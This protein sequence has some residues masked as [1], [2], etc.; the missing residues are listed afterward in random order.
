VTIY[1]GA[2]TR[3]VAFTTDVSGQVMR[4]LDSSGS[5]NLAHDASYRLGGRTIGE[6]SSSQMLATQNGAFYADFDQSL[7]SLH[8][9]QE[10][11]GGSYTVL[12][13]ETLRSIAGKLWGD[14][15][16]WY[17]LA[18]ANGLTGSETLA[19]GSQLVVPAGVSTYRNAADTFR[20]Y[21]PNAA[22]G[23]L[24][25]GE[26]YQ[27]VQATP[28]GRKGNKCGMFG[29]VLLIIVAIAVTK[30]AGPYVGSVVASIGLSGTAAAVA[31]AAATAA[32]ASTVSQGVGLATGIQDKFSWKQ[33]AIAA[34]TAGIA[35]GLEHSGAFSSLGI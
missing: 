10:A 11:A 33:V 18:D 7:R 8:T 29:M 4:R 12:A 2:Q 14:A 23:N 6:V 34:A 28:Q 19:E 25:P 17:K 1:E 35:R 3:N 26:P 27:A 32:I 13:G 22:M 5:Q 24:E 15:S 16:L 9:E 20:P 30:I 31:T 21:D